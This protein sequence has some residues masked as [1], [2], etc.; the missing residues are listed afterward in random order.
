MNTDCDGL[1][2]AS[3]LARKKAAAIENVNTLFAAVPT[4]RPVTEV[5]LQTECSTPKKKRRKTPLDNND[6]TSSAVQV[7]AKEIAKKEK[8]ARA[9][10]AQQAAPGQ[11]QR[12]LTL[13]RT[14]ARKNEK[15]K[16][17]SSVAQ[18]DEKKKKSKNKN[19]TVGG[20]ST[21]RKEQKATSSTE[22]CGKRNDNELSAEEKSV[23]ANAEATKASAQD[24]KAPE[25]EMRKKRPQLTDEQKAERAGR[26]VFVGNVPLDMSVKIMRKLAAKAPINVVEV[27]GASSDVQPDVVDGATPSGPA[28]SGHS[29]SSPSQPS[30]PKASSHIDSSSQRVAVEAVYFRSVPVAEKWKNNKKVGAA[31]Q[32]FAVNG[33]TSKNCYVVVKK[34][35]HMQAMISYLHKRE[36]D[37]HVLRA[38]GN[39]RN[40]NDAGDAAATKE[41]SR[42]KTVF[43]GNLAHVA[44]EDE[45]R[46]AFTEKSLPV[47][48]VRIIR[49]RVTHAGKGIGFVQFEKRASVPLAR[50]LKVVLHE[51]TL[52]VEKVE[53]EETLRERKSWW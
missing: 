27:S 36:I 32:E 48:K 19:D 17:S 23:T 4:K 10:A 12:A 46:L 8:P 42:K 24:A 22:E 52:R 31:R 26:T 37:G 15:A 20:G 25:E 18:P 34:K 45:L 13:C 50:S 1:N 11:L 7:P 5:L 47:N 30:Q 51:R 43:I 39:G 41:F 53:D 2:F 44:T 33:G 21:G 29:A 6:D 16:Q 35:E 3:L 14:V 40:S 38:D 9:S 28:I 49:D